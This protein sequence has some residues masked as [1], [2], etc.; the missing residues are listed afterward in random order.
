VPAAAGPTRPGRPVPRRYDAGPVTDANGAMPRSL[1]LRLLPP[2]AAYVT[3]RLA[4]A[5]ATGTAPWALDAAT[6]GRWDSGN[7]ADIA[8][9]GYQWASCA[10]Q[11]RPQHGDLCS[12]AAWYP[13][14]P[15]L[16][17][18]V[19][20][21]SRISID[22]AL[23]LLAHAGFIALLVVVWLGLLDDDRSARPDPRSF[24]LLALVAF[25]PG[26]VYLLGAFPLSLLVALLALQVAWFVRDRW[27]PGA[28]AGAL[29]SLCYP[30]TAVLPVA[31]AVWVLIADRT[32][33]RTRRCLRALG[34]GAAVLA[35]TLAVFALHQVTLDDWSAALDEQRRFGGTLYNPAFNWAHTVLRRNSWIQLH[36]PATAWPVAAQTALVTIFVALCAVMVVRDRGRPDSPLPRPLGLAHRWRHEVGLLVLVV[37][38]WLLPLASNIETGLYRRVLPL[39]PGVWLLR[40]APWPVLAVLTAASV[41]LWWWMAPL[42]N[43]GELI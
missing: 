1:P 27:W 38:L 24:I 5:A 25:F 16:A 21:V 14:Y 29:A 19:S 12:T 34:V 10:A 26:G 8:A 11:N 13:A 40:R 35:G 7:Y 22:Q 18:A 28:T 37:A 2:A 36:A 30:I 23:V 32:P 17:R 43:S 15:F 33:D 39:I 4:Y 20:E 42:F 6:F 3:V 9:N 41:A 31:S